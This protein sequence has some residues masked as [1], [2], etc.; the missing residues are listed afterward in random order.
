M[1]GCA[2][3]FRETV[4]LLMAVLR[5]IATCGVVGIARVAVMWRSIGGRAS[6]AEPG[7]QKEVAMDVEGSERGNRSATGDAG[8]SR[9]C[10]V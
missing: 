8:R 3:W 10:W 9:L 1:L 2:V 4:P 6:S 7:R 5:P